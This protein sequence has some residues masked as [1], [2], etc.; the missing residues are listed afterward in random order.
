MQ[1]AYTEKDRRYYIQA[2][3]LDWNYAPSGTA[4]PATATAQYQ[5]NPTQS[6][7]INARLLLSAFEWHL[8]LRG[9]L[10]VCVLRDAPI[11]CLQRSQVWREVSW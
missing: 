10:E 4:P 6:N 11:A 7:A 8:S 3:L 9:V 5:R 2:E 1:P